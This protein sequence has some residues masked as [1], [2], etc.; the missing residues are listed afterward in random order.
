MYSKLQDGNIPLFA[1]VEAGNIHVCRELLLQETESQLKYT[2]PPLK[3]LVLHLAA[4][5]RD[6]D[7]VKLFIEAGAVVDGT[8]VRI[9]LRIVF[10]SSQQQN[11]IDLLQLVFSNFLMMF[12]LVIFES[13]G[14][15][16]A[17][18]LLL[19]A[20]HAFFVFYSTCD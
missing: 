11:G 7:M 14:I 13:H 6:N 3:D 10:L 15:I 19:V 2:K 1:A 12:Q 8:N 16:E 18:S 20:S 5:K 4:R 9:A 17:S